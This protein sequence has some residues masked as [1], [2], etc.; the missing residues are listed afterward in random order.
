MRVCALVFLV[1][2]VAASEPAPARSVPD[3][4]RVRALRG[5]LAETQLDLMQVMRSPH[6]SQ[7]S[8]RAQEAGLKYAIRA[9]QIRQAERAECQRRREA[10]CGAPRT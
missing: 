9:E 4:D 1:A 6:D 3:S 5:Q 8:L 10:G 7:E 2:G